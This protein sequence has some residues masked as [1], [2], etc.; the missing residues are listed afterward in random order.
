MDFR[1]VDVP[2]LKWSATPKGPRNVQRV[3]VQT[4]R[5]NCFIIPSTGGMN[6]IE[7]R[8]PSKFSDF[9]DGIDDSAREA[10][11]DNDAGFYSSTFNGKMRLTSFSDVL[12]FDGEGALSQDP[13]SAKSAA[14][15]LEL[16]GTWSAGTKK[17]VRWKVVQLKFWTE[18]V[19][20]EM[21]DL[22]DDCPDGADEN[23]AAPSASAVSY[24]FLDD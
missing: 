12:C 8:V 9:L 21:T 23:S 7:L 17:G 24:A 18:G 14:A 22:I 19:P 2:A 11:G 10:L 1:N 4:P 3:V 16:G 20:L 5:C 13:T 15:V 6:K